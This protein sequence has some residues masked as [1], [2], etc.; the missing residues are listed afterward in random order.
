MP[1]NLAMKVRRVLALLVLASGLPLATASAAHGVTCPAKPDL[2]E[3]VTSAQIVFAGRVSDVDESGTVATVQVLGIWKASAPSE[4][5]AS[6]QVTGGFEG[7]PEFR[8]YNKSATYLFFPANRRAPFVDPV[9]SPTRLYSGSILAIPPYLTEA[10]GSANAVVPSDAETDEPSSS[11]LTPIAIGILVLLTLVGVI[12]LYSRA[13]RFDSRPAQESA[14]KPIFKPVKR[15][16]REGRVRG[17]TDKAS[18]SAR[19]AGRLR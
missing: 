4:I 9:C 12:R 3:A 5:P 10:T 6:V 11:V 1:I 13:V 16:R 7:D 17:Y 2:E 8:R 18:R 14:E 15:R 19:R